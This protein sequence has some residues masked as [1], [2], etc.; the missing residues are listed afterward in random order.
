MGPARAV[1]TWLP[2]VTFVVTTKSGFRAAGPGGGFSLETHVAWTTLARPEACKSWGC[3]VEQSGQRLDMAVPS[4]RSVPG[5]A[6]SSDCPFKGGAEA[7]EGNIRRKE[8]TQNDPNCGREDPPPSVHVLPL[9]WLCGLCC[10]II[11][12]LTYTRL[13]QVLIML[14][15][16]LAGRWCCLLGGS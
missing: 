1:G 13:H 12:V 7:S 16:Q 10:Y 8:N 9:G 11:I 14:S 4:A 3:G 6:L 15:G 5:S 2:T